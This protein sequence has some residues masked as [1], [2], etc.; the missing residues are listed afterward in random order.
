MP[1]DATLG[2]TGRGRLAQRLGS[3]MQRGWVWPLGVG[4]LRF[5]TFLLW[6]RY[7]DAPLDVDVGIYATVAYWW[8]RGDVLYA[9]ITADR[10]Q[11]IFVIFRAIDALGLGLAWGIHLFAAIYAACCTL[12]LP[13]VVSRIWGR[14]LWLAR[15]W[16]AERGGARAL[17]VGLQ[18]HWRA[19]SCWDSCPRPST[20]SPS[21]PIVTS[22][23]FSSTVSAPSRRRQSRRVCNFPPSPVWC[24]T[25]SFATR[26]YCWHRWDSQCSAASRAAVISS[27]LAAD[28]AARCLDGRQLVPA[29]FSASVAAVGGGRRARTARAGFLGAAAATGA[30]VVLAAVARHHGVES[31]LSRGDGRPRAP[32][33]R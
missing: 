17:G 27:A 16:R 30:V 4:V 20:V 25:S 13:F 28:F 26:C 33:I 19:V 22:M 8:A 24:S 14:A 5:G 10:P 23:R 9:Q 1:A 12:T 21:R 29:L 32:A 2:L 18:P 31:H 7:L 15:R 11:G 6:L 3:R